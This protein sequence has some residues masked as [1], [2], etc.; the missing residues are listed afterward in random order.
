[1]MSFIRIILLSILIYLFYKT[2]KNVI[3]FLTSGKS[4]SGSNE[5]GRKKK[6]K[7]KIEK[8]DVIDAHFE[9]ISSDKTDKQKE[10]S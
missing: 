6:S 4:K 8:E 7:Y 10:N 3:K 1:M 2:V 5:V 9:E